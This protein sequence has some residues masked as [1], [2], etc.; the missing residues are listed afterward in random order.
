MYPFP[1]NHIKRYKFTIYS[2]LIFK[3]SFNHKTTAKIRSKKNSGEYLQGSFHVTLTR[4]KLSHRY[5]IKCLSFSHEASNFK[6]AEHIF[7]FY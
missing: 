2:I 7:I 6:K 5:F 3:N 1:A 4:I